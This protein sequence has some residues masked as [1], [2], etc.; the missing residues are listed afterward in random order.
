MVDCCT[1]PFVFIDILAL[2]PKIHL[3]TIS[4]HLSAT[5]FPDGADP[6]V[7]GLRCPEG[8]GQG[9]RHNLTPRSVRASAD[10]ILAYKFRNSLPRNFPAVAYLGASTES[11]KGWRG[12][13]HLGEEP[14]RP[15]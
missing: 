4:F 3:S 9:E 5:P 12:P 8:T 11:L 15:Q 13:Q 10:P 1:D 6:A 7:W 14:L 2:F